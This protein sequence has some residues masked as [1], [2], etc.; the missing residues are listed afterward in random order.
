MRQGERRHGYTMLEVQVAFAVLG[1]AMAGLCPLVVMQLRQVRQLELRLQGQVVQLNTSTGGSETMLAGK[2]Y[3]VVPWGN[4][5][6]R[7]LAASA[8]ILGSAKSPCDPGPLP[9]PVPA[10]TAYPVSVVELD[11]PPYSQTVTVYV[12]VSAP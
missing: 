7:K 8:Q 3:Y 10:P 11:A 5:W 4:P 12:D 6:T 2:T 1:I 9:V